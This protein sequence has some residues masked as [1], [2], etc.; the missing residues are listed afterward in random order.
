MKKKQKYVG[1]LLTLAL[2]CTLTACGGNSTNDSNS[3]S[4]DKNN[5]SANAETTALFTFDDVSI[6]VPYYEMVL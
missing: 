1:L 2:F 6:S 3:N 4:A 5:I